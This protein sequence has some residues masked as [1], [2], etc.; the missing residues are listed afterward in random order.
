MILR[1]GY[2]VTSEMLDAAEL[3]SL[4]EDEIAD[5]FEISRMGLWKVRKRLGCPQK[6]RSDKGKNRVEP[7]P[8]ILAKERR[9][10]YMREWRARQPKRFS[11]D[12]WGIRSIFFEAVGRH[13][14]KG[15]VVH[16]VDGN[17]ENNS[18]KNL[19]ICT[20]DYHMAIFHSPKSNPIGA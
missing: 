20:H 1:N 12:W 6:V 11:R 13:P 8:E 3:N 14:R 9:N 7:L 19:V 2:E 16:H 10:K 4:S 15:E 5:S 18:H 17:P